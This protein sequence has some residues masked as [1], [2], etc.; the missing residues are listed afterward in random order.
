[1]FDLVVKKQTLHMKISLSSP[2]HIKN[3]LE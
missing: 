2:A 1:M 3:E